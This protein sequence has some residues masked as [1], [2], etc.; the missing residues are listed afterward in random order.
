MASVSPIRDEQAPQ[1]PGHDA[2]TV[3]KRRRAPLVFGGLLLAAVGIAAYIY[4][5]RLGREKTD[6]AQVE[7]HVSNVS[8]RIAGQVKRV[9]VADNQEVK[10]GDVLVEL[11]DR[12]YGAKLAASKADLAAATASL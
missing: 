3:K 5:S 2:P 6:D 8:A 11:D 4:L 12:D 10:A 1:I 9:L 7:A